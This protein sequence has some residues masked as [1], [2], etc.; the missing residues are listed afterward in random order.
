MLMQRHGAALRVL[1]HRR[2]AALQVRRQGLWRGR[3]VW[4]PHWMMAED[5]NKRSTAGEH[6][7]CSNSRQHAWVPTVTALVSGPYSAHLCIT[8]AQSSANKGLDA[9]CTGSGHDSESHLRSETAQAWQALGLA[10]GHARGHT[11][12]RV[13]ARGL[14]ACPWVADALGRGRC[15]GVALQAPAS[16][17][18][19]IPLFSQSARC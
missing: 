7:A 14:A 18:M 15:Q 3:H 16:L 19:V 8:A 11:V 17:S 9:S 4:R 6:A 2:R 5:C 13:E 12:V 10:P 1:M